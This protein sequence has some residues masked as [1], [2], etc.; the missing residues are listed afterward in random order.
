MN[1]I[2]ILATIAHNRTSKDISEVCYHIYEDVKA[3][4]NSHF[5]FVTLWYLSINNLVRK[6]S[7]HIHIFVTNRTSFLVL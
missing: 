4:I 5:N 1:D 6:K 7:L 3:D 2:I